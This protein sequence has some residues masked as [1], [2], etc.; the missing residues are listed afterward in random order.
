MKKYR[1]LYLLVII[2]LLV[3]ACRKEKQEENQLR[4]RIESYGEVTQITIYHRGEN[5]SGDAC[6]TSDNEVINF[7]ILYQ[8][9]NSSDVEEILDMLEGWNYEEHT[10]TEVL[11]LVADVEICFHGNERFIS[12]ASD[13][14][15]RQYYGY[16]EGK[17]YYLPEKLCKFIEGLLMK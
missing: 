6:I 10:V 3:S 12:Y 17:P 16:I 5:T 4:D 15:Q 1:I 13:G 14:I 2:I 9:E 11:D 8:T 7:D